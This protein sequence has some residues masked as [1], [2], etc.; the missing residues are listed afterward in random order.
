[1]ARPIFG[2][3]TVTSNATPSGVQQG[4][5]GGIAPAAGG[6]PGMK[7]MVGDEVYLWILVVIEV[8]LMGYLRKLSRRHHGG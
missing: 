6:R 3:N 5:L 1:M 7:L 2:R 4:T 8:L